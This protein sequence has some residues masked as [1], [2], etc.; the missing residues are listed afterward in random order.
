[1]TEYE[2]KLEARAR[3]LD[4]STDHSW[5]WAGFFGIIY[6]L[7]FGF[8][9]E[10]LGILVASVVIMSVVSTYQIEVYG[11]IPTNYV[12]SDFFAMGLMIVFSALMANPAW[13]RRATAKARDQIIYEA[14]TDAKD[15]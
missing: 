12:G 3:Q 1:M 15:T 6:Y 11:D 4:E 14:M 13:K 5:L 10:A 9:K 8:W 7:F 2:I